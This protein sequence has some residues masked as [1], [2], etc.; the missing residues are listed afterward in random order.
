MVQVGKSELQMTSLFISTPIHI[1]W[2]YIL[3]NVYGLGVVGTGLAGMF[4]NLFQ[5]LY[6]IYQT[7]CIEELEAANKV[8]IFNW[9]VY[10]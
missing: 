7:N 9:Q 4:T 10:D 2:N 6:T 8:S 5:L 1:F 3:V